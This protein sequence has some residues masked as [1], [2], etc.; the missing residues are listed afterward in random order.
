MRIKTHILYIVTIIVLILLLVEPT[1]KSDRVDGV[2]DSKV[3]T[4]SFINTIVIRDTIIDTLVI[5]KDK[6]VKDTVRISDTNLGFDVYL[7]VVQ[8]HYSEKE[9]Y[10]LWISG[11]EPLNLDR[12]DIYKEVEYKTIT[13]TV[14]KTQ[15]VYPKNNELYLGGGF[16]S[17]LDTF[18]P[19]VNVSLKTKKNALISLNLGRYKGDNLVVGTYSWKLGRNKY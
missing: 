11:V 8:K 14:T 2:S 16:Y 18:T 6:I 12:I 3:D 9:R 13:N 10:D 15:Y 1:A 17:F 4:L 19:V 5:Y 7:P